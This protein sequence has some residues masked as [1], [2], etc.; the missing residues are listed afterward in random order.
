MNLSF[1]TQCFSLK[2]TLV[3]TGFFWYFY[4]CGCKLKIRCMY[5]ANSERAFMFHSCILRKGHI[6]LGFLGTLYS[7]PI[8][9]WVIY[10]IITSTAKNARCHTCACQVLAWNLPVFC[11]IEGSPV[12]SVCVLNH[13]KASTI[14][15]FFFFSLQFWAWNLSSCWATVYCV[16][17]EK[18]S[19]VVNKEET[20]PTG[21][22]S[23]L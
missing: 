17:G 13:L 22:F 21:F 8:K 9:D 18:I 4:V 7:G 16:F 3:Y 2:L 15:W 19:T 10:T 5:I 6:F 23:I 14:V 1:I 20:L 12:S 11:S